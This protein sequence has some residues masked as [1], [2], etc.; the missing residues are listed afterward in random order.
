MR[1]LLLCIYLFYYWVGA[2]T[3]AFDSDNLLSALAQK[4]ASV[5]FKGFSKFWLLNKENENRERGIKV[6]FNPITDTVESIII[7]G[8]PT[9][10]LSNS[11]V[12]KCTARLPMQISLDDDTTALVAKLGPGEKLPGRNT[13]KFHSGNI[14]VEAT[15]GDLKTGKIAYLK[16]ST[17]V[18]TTVIAPAVIPVV[19]KES[20][21]N[22]SDEL[23]KDIFLNTGLSAGGYSKPKDTVVVKPLKKALLDIFKASK[24]FAFLNIK[25]D[26]RTDKNFWNYKYT[27][28]TNIKIPGEKYNMLYSFP[29]PNSELDFVV[30]LKESDK[31]DKSFETIYRSFEKQLNENFPESEGWVFTCLPSKD[32]NPLPDLEYRN[33]KFG[34]IIL[35]HTRSPAGKHVLYLRFLLFA[36]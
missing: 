28:N 35:D 16:F 26:E 18:P 19:K 33:D 24:Q 21:T 4:S 11:K 27:Y 34:A 7:T 12:A 5:T 8:Y 1:F 14:A 20:I 31:Y 23:E 25:T 6:Y 32:K 2:P 29:F 15:Y 13:W 3:V 36:D 22:K 17:Y 30:V 10:N 9:T